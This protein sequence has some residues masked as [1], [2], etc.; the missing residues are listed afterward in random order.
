MNI[1][2][3][4]MALVT[5][6]NWF[7]APNGKQYMSVFGKVKAIQNDQETLGIKTNARSANW[8][9]EIGNMTIAGCQIH[10]AI[11]TNECNFG[12]VDAY[13]IKDGECKE[14][15]RPSQIY[16]AGE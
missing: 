10:Y 11:K 15:T 9:L 8:Y 3:G 16:N 5:T 12:R 2:I 14:Y 7:M 4:D 1:E 6:S 13:D